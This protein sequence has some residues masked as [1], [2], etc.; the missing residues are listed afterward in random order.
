MCYIFKLRN[1]VFKMLGRKSKIKG[2]GW[3]HLFLF[4]ILLT[5]SA[6]SYSK[7]I[8]NNYFTGING[9][10]LENVKKHLAVKQDEIS[11]LAPD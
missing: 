8:L 11:N 2:G 7:T 3:G 9:P 4:V 10:I 1:T 6:A 5:I